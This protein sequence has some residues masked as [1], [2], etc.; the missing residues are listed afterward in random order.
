MYWFSE[1]VK[2][3]AIDWRPEVHDSDGLAMWTGSGEHIWRPLNNPA[4]I[5]VSASATRTRRAS[6][7]CSAT[8]TSTITWTASL[9]PPPPSLGRAAGRLGQGRIQLVEL[10][11]DDEIHDN[12]VATGCRRRRRPATQL[13]FAYRLHWLADEPYPTPLARVVAT[14]LGRGGQPGQPRPDGVRK[15][16]VEFLGGPL[17]NLPFGVKPE[18]VLWASRGTFSTYTLME[19]VP[20]DVPGHWRD[21]VRPAGRRRRPGRDAPVPQGRRPGGV[22]DLAVPVPTLRLRR[23]ACGELIPGPASAEAG[24]PTWQAVSLAAWS[25]PSRPGRRRTGGCTAWRGR[26]AAA[27]GAGRGRRPRWSG[28]R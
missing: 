5:V 1:T 15:F 27:S 20:D 16:M 17:T 9:S 26:A 25:R 19:A 24:L 21:P 8:A 13:T 12:I 3:T 2:P 28:C 23:P 10:P 6:A 14:R 11:T 22:R 4:R 7:C 18:P